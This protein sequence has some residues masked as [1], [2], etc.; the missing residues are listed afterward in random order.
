MSV[1]VL[2]LASEF[3]PRLLGGLGTSLRGLT[4]GSARLGMT[5]GVLLFEQER[6]VQARGSPLMGAESF[7]TPAL[8]GTGSI[9]SRAGGFRSAK[10]NGS[11]PLAGNASCLDSG[12]IGVELFEVREA[13]AGEGFSRLIEAWGP[14]VLHVHVPWLWPGAEEAR[15]KAKVR[16]V[17]TAH[18]LARAERDIGGDM[19]E[20]VAN[21]SLQEASIDGADR[22]VAV[23]R[24][25]AQLIA[26][27]YPAA[28]PKLRLVGHAAPWP[29][30]DG[31]SMSSL[32]TNAD[33]MV[34]FAGRLTERKGVRDLLAAFAL[35][36]DVIPEAW[37]VMAGGEPGT[38]ADVLARRWLSA[39][40]QREGRVRF[41]GWLSQPELRQWYRRATVLAV[42]SRYEPF[43]LVAMEAMADRLPVVASAVGGLAEIVRHEHTGLLV[44]PRDQEALADALL[45]VL[46]DARLHRQLA[47][48]AALEVRNRSTWTSIAAGMQSLYLEALDR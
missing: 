2:H 7:L 42:P 41:T 17:C 3:P 8:Y 13:D 48:S 21:G 47:E 6:V 33:P 5:V 32:R 39:A 31:S 34:L 24:S 40:E 12:V 45:R 35:I 20:W 16:I 19:G 22:I 28:V 37:L 27:Y 30:L 23:S 46:R 26:S 9:A 44:P 43:G 1:R 15:R 25:E 29:V 14:D 10:V 36:R 18:S 11:A 38:P 4:E